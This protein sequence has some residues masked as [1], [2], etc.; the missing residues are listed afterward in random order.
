MA[1]QFSSF[2]LLA[3]LAV[4]GSGSAQA[5]TGRPAAVLELCRA[6]VQA[7]QGTADHDQQLRRC[8]GRRME[9]RAAGGTP[10][11]EQRP[12]AS[13]P[14]SA[15]LARRIARALPVL[16]EADGER[17]AADKRALCRRNEVVSY[18]Q[19]KP[20][21]VPDQLEDGLPEALR[22]YALEPR[23]WRVVEAWGRLHLAA[24]YPEEDCPDINQFIAVTR[25]NQALG[26]PRF[27][28][29][30]RRFIRRVT[31]SAI[32]DAEAK[33]MVPLEQAAAASAAAARVQQRLESERRRRETGPEGDQR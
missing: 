32:R 7:P 24:A 4:S 5:Q 29:R 16:R 23:V 21:L 25:L 3:W 30:G 18:L 11:P 20:Y 6:E 19:G 13:T 8:I 17:T 28:G 9:Q 22:Q 2:F 12:E 33:L 26:E 15:E 27:E 14:G 10:S 1:S 31:M